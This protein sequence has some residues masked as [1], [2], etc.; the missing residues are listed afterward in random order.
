MCQC[1]FCQNK[2]KDE[3]TL[4]GFPATHNAQA[5]ALFGG[6]SVV[7]SVIRKSPAILAK[8][9][10][11]HNQASDFSLSSLAVLLP[12]K[13]KYAKTKSATSTL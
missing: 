4:D 10:K 2:V 9:I 1:E 6:L 13:D 11:P 5:F 3:P 12:K 7:S 8:W